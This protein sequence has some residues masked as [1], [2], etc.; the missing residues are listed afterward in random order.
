M[1]DYNLLEHNGKQVTGTITVSA[2][3]G[4]APRRRR[5]R[6]LVAELH[7]AQH[8]DHKGVRAFARMPHLG[9]D[10]AVAKMGHP[11]VGD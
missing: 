9:N 5:R 3:A 6:P 11:S 2:R 8:V 4:R 7:L 10:E 1:P